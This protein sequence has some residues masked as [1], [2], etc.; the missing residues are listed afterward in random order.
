ML[1]KIT[2][3]AAVTLF[4]CVAPLRADSVDG[5]PTHPDDPHVPASV[6]GSPAILFENA[7]GPL[8]SCRDDT[9]TGAC[10]A[11]GRF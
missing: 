7:R 5:K 1:A 10:G 9:S 2:L 4:V 11:G 8:D 3:I 6:R